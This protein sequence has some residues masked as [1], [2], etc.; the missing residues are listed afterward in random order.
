MASASRPKRRV[1]GRNLK[2]NTPFITT[3][4]NSKRG[5]VYP[6]SI[7]D[8]D[9]NLVRSSR[10]KGKKKM[11]W[12]RKKF[13]EWSRQAWED[14][15]NE[16]SNRHDEVWDTE[17]GPAPAPLNSSCYVQFKLHHASGG[18]VVEHC[19]YD[20]ESDRYVSPKLTVIHSDE[21]LGKRLK[22]IVFMEGLK[23]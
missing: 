9:G 23:S 15:K 1:N 4:G 13:M 19:S 14:S 10:R 12:F 20:S 5:R 8:N 11:N 6:T 21:D 18:F 22:D 16:N 3:S 7:M 2:S 17:D